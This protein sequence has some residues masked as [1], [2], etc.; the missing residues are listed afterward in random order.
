VTISVDVAIVGGGI[1][2]LAVADAITARWP[3]KTVAVL[4]KEHELGAHQTGRNSGV[5]HSGIYYK[6]GSVK[7]RLCTAGNAS[8][9]RFA[10]VNGIPHERCGKLIVATDT[11]ALGRLGDLERRAAANGIEAHRIDAA[12]VREHEPNVVGL[13]G[14]WIPSTGIIDYRIVLEVLARR[15][16]ES[17]SEVLLDAEVTGFALEN[18]EH[19]L[20]TKAGDVVAAFLVGCA[21]LQ[22]DRVA[23]QAGAEL[24]DRI[25]P[26]R[27]EYFEL[28]PERRSLIKGLVYPVPDPNF[29]F[30]GVHFTRMI[31]GS[32][33]AGPNA[34]VA[35]AREGYR[36]RDVN[37]HDIVDIVGFPG[38]W[39]LARRHGRAGM[40]ELARSLSKRRFVKSLQELVPTVT[41][42][43]L[44]PSDAGVRAQLLERSGALVDDFKIVRAERSLH[45]CNAPSPA[46]TSSL[47]IGRLVADELV[48]AL[49]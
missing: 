17:G 36:K 41:A 26:F 13:G 11:E 20:S 32:V 6:P 10:E 19:R 9:F 12:Q 43:D 33:H 31:D 3:E 23:R 38:F 22:S 34:V 47:E 21:G 5:I 8:M 48:E 44:E 29:P 27:G 46:A 30:L 45:V 1:V 24:S 25:V 42:N 2:G 37:L 35:L 39:R 28:V 16:R 49:G 14:L 18:G 40:G 15:L 7:A 4:E